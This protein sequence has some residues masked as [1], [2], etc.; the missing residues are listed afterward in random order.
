M[1]FVTL[2]IEWGVPLVFAAVVLEQIGL[3]LPAPPILV[4][5]GAL[6]ADGAMRPELVLLSAFGACLLADHI[7]FASGRRFG[8]RLLSGI[9]R[10]SLSP[11]TC[12]RKTDDLI[13]RHGPA[14]LL[15]AK[16]IP[17]V[18]AVAIPTAAAMGLAYRRFVLFDSVG[19][20]L[21]SGVY[22]GAGVIFSREVTRM[23]LAM[24]WIGGGSLALLFALLAIY[25][26]AKLLHRR[27][28]RR[29]HRLVRI[30]PDE[31]VA[32]LA[33][34]P[35]VVI[36]DARTS[37]ARSEDPRLLPRSIVLADR[38]AIDVLPQG[39]RDQ[40][41]VTFCTCPNEASA[42]LL[43]EELIKAGYGRVRVLTG[44]ADAVELLS[45]YS[46]DYGALA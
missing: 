21:W 36:L 13:G 12:V 15:V 34:D 39:R 18:S 25:V 20:L 24:S 40:T 5:A 26:A 17:G 14:V 30:S 22:V 3:P 43:A 16:F 35:E 19:A 29:L 10:L 7:W 38:K 32:L 23:L 6:A 33:K 44:G 9:C 1:D 8:R 31:I 42:A 46:S 27:R 2:L 4:A 41:L 45:A 37:L 28:L 11:D